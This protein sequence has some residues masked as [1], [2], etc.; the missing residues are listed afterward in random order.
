M[1]T[2]VPGLQSLLHV[3]I[4]EIRHRGREA[5]VGTIEIRKVC[6]FLKFWQLDLKFTV[7]TWLKDFLKDARF[8][9]RDF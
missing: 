9:F 7:I 8:N 6:H 4:P 3:Y 2:E 5:S 1:C